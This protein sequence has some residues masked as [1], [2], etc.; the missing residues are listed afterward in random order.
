[1]VFTGGRSKPDLPGLPGE[2]ALAR[3]ET[4]AVVATPA[5]RRAAKVANRAARVASVKD[6]AIV[7]AGEGAAVDAAAG[8]SVRAN[9]KVSERA[10]AI[11]RAAQR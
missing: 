4:A 11:S 6:A 8:R 7:V 3:V 1:V 5:R 2:G 10:M 9:R